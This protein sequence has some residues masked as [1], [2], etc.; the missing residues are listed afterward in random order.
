MNSTNWINSIN[1]QEY[2][3][4]SFLR[5]NHDISKQGLT[6]ELNHPFSYKF[7]CPQML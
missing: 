3:P 2:L 4:G 6:E 7:V 1:E 5:S